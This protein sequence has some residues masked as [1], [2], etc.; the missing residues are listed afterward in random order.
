MAK[1]LKRF[2]KDCPSIDWCLDAFNR[3]W[4]AKSN[5]GRGCSCPLPPPP[6]SMR[7][8]PRK[9]PPV[10]TQPELLAEQKPS[11]PPPITD[12]CF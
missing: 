3:Y 7:L 5:N 12:D 9:R 4:F 8:K 1:E 10:V 11:Q 6:P 2:C